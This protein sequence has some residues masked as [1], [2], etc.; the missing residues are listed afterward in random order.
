MQWRFRERSGF[1]H[2]SFAKISMGVGSKFCSRSAW[3]TVGNGV[4]RDRVIVVE[5]HYRALR[6]RSGPHTAHDLH[7]FA[8]CRKVWAG[9]LD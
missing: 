3:I 7:E 2:N 8:T 4:L 6:R 1:G 9:R 5:R